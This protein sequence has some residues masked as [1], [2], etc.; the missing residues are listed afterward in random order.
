MFCIL[1][2]FTSV[3]AQ[4]A[5]TLSVGMELRLQNTIALTFSMYPISNDG[6]KGTASFRLYKQN[7]Y[8]CL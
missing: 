7:E 2:A 1:N 4:T 6:Y 3:K 8:V 5:D